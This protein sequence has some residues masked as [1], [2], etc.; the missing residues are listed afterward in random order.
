MAT[1]WEYVE[2][3]IAHDDKGNSYEIDKEQLIGTVCPNSGPNSGQTRSTAGPLRFRCNGE[4]V[5]RL[6]NGQYQLVTGIILT[7]DLPG[8]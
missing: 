7:P 2:S 3:I 5:K 4:P 6:L 8:A 1:N